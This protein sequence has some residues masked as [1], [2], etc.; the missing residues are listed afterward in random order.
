MAGSPTVALQPYLWDHHIPSSSL[1][2][3]L[4]WSPYSNW[5]CVLLGLKRGIT[6]ILVAFPQS[7]KISG[8]CPW[9]L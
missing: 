7:W 2:G 5:P 1:L 4:I 8:H 9:S 6:A 3:I